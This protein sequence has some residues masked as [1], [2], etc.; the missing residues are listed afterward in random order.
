MKQNK[1]EVKKLK[2]EYCND[3]HLTIVIDGVPLDVILHNLYPNN[4]LL[5]L[6][7]TILDWIDNI[8]E[9]E[10]IKL[11]FSSLKDEEVLPI[12]ICPDDCDLWCTVIVAKV[13]QKNEFIIWDKIGID[14]SSREKLL[15]GYD[16]IGSKVKW[17]DKAH[18]LT[19]NIDE[20]N[21]ELNKI[22]A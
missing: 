16:C 19:F 17:L 14:K 6:V 15:N 11:R 7:P 1:I 22:Y 5:G 3:K 18:S 9:K 21:T 2:S 20:Y 12:L 13:L 8:K 10:L 4:R